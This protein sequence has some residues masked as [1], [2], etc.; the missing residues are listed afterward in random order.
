AE[1]SDSLGVET[2]WPWGPSVD[3]LNADGWDDVFVANSMN[4]PYPYAANDVFLNEAGKRFLSAAFTLGVEPRRDGA[5]E[6]VWFVAACGPNGADR[7]GKACQSCSQPNAAESGCRMDADG[8]ATMTATRGT[9]SAVIFDV[10]RDGDL[11]IITNEFNAS[12][13]VLLS[14]LSAKHAVHSLT[15]RLRG[16]T[17]NRQGVGAQVT[18]VLRDGRRI[19]KV[20]D[21]QSGYLSHSDLPLYFGLGTADAAASIEVRW[22]SGKRQVVSGPIASGTRVDVVEP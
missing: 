6:Q 7:N 18:V 10:D 21:G 4:F 12:P 14:N 3:D 20:N 16:T 19:L 9:R 1:V 8:N 15:V 17:S 11:D 13:Q 2:Y 5:T 22:P